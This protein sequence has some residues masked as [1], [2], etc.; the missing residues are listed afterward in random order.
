MDPTIK[1]LLR[2]RDERNRLSHLIFEREDAQ[3]KHEKLTKVAKEVSDEAYQYA[4][5]ERNTDLSMLDY[6]SDRLE[7]KRLE[8]KARELGVPIP[9]RPNGFDENEHWEMSIAGD[10]VLSVKGRMLLRREIALERELAQKP[11]L[12]WAAVTLSVLSLTISALNGI[13]G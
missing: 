7:T 3:V 1:K 11:V 10:H 4:M 5:A 2:W 6:Q 8:R 13:F 9:T 12:S